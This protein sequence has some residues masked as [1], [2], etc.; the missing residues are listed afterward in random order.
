[1]HEYIHVKLF[2]RDIDSFH[3]FCRN[4]IHLHLNEFSWVRPIYRFL[5]ESLFLFLRTTRDLISSAT[6]WWT[7]SLII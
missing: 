6:L 7:R 5:E 1:M 4:Y 3:W 2:V